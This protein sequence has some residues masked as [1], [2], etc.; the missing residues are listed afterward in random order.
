MTHSTFPAWI[1]DG[2]PIDDPAIFEDRRTGEMIGGGE[3]AVEFLRRLKHPKSTAPGRAFQLDPWQERI[4]RRI[5]GPRH[6]EDVYSSDG[7]LLHKRGERIVKQVVL[8]LPRGNRKTSLSA[9]LALLHTIGPEREPGGE[10]IFAA[11]DRTQAGIGFREASS[12]IQADR[13]LIAATSIYDA[14]NSAKKIVRRDDGSFLEIVSSDGKRQHGRTPTFV[15]A[16]ELHI[17]QGEALLEALES[18]LDKT[19]KGLLII[20]TTAGRGQ[21]TLAWRK[22]EQARAVAR[23]GLANPTIL[24]VIFEASADDDWKDEALWRRVNPGM[25]HGY[26]PLSELQGKAKLAEHS[27]VERESFRQLKLNVWLDRSTDPFVD[28]A[29][30]DRGAAPIDLD[31]LAGQPCWIGVDMSTVG[32][33]TAVVAAFRDPEDEDGFVVLPQFFLPGE[34]VRART[35]QDG[36]PYTTWAEDG[37]I[38]ATPGN[39]IDTRAVEAHIRALAATYDVREIAFDPAYAAP[40]MHPLTDD[41]FP[42]ATL[43]QGW[44]TQ[45][46]ALNVLEGAIVAGKLRHGGHPVLRWCFANVAINTDSAGNRTMHKGKSHGD[47]NRRIDG[48]VATWMAISRAAATET[49]P[50]SIFDSPDWDDSLGAW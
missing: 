26:P 5:Y 13:R 46:P 35:H 28:M 27:P 34:N 36:V 11:S 39:R 37:F 16:D 12:I 4:V 43:R 44:V 10:A 31:T 23:G 22:I 29:V 2:S 17:W 20:A 30:Y 40:V 25:V 9:A 1:Y 42:T 50:K 32:D 24:P 19:T 3:R 41:G 8:L 6:L 14:H 45:S 18:G 38:V 21:D 48:A 47:K 49:T 7:I 15:L 33:L